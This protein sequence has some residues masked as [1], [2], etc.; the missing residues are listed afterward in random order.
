MICQRQDQSY[1]LTADV[2]QESLD[3]IE[4]IEECNISTKGMRER[5]LRPAW[6]DCSLPDVT[7]LAECRSVLG[8]SP[9]PRW[10]PASGAGVESCDDVCRTER[11]VNIW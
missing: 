6:H 10:R 11:V 1:A 2:A 5:L 8:E 4:T 9:A 3:A 7:W